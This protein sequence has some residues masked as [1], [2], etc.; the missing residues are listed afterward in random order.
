M[1]IQTCPPS[2]TAIFVITLKVAR[3]PSFNSL[4]LNGDGSILSSGIRGR[5]SGSLTGLSSLRT[6]L[7]VENSQMRGLQRN[8]V[9]NRVQDSGL[10][11]D[12][13]SQTAS[14]LVL[15]RIYPRKL[16]GITGRYV[17]KMRTRPSKPEPQNSRTK[18][19]F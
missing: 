18:P 12:P 2:S 7:Q 13:M 15:G 11:C 4:N 1:S 16:Y 6:A 3:S 14:V 8:S 9:L 19:R 5:S 17:H 10:L